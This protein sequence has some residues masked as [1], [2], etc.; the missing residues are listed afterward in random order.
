MSLS[1]KIRKAVVSLAVVSVT[2]TAMPV[3]LSDT[4]P[5]VSTTNTAEIEK[6]I[7]AETLDSTTTTVEP[8]PNTA[9]TTTAADP[10]AEVPAEATPNINFPGDGD[11]KANTAELITKDAPQEIQLKKND[12]GTHTLST[13][14]KATP[15]GGPLGI[16]NFKRLGSKLPNLVI[17]DVTVGTSDVIP[18]EYHPDLER[19]LGFGLLSVDAKDVS[20]TTDQKVVVTYTLTDGETEALKD[21]DGTWEF[22]NDLKITA[23]DKLTKVALQ[24]AN[25]LPDSPRTLRTRPWTPVVLSTDNIISPKPFPDECRS[26]RTQQWGQCITKRY[27]GPLNDEGLAFGDDA[28]H[29]APTDSFRFESRPNY[30]IYQRNWGANHYPQPGNRQLRFPFRHSGNRPG[31]IDLDSP[32]NTVAEQGLFFS[33]DHVQWAWEETP[34][35]NQTNVWRAHEFLIGG[36]YQDGTYYGGNYTFT[37]AGGPAGFFDVPKRKGQVPWRIYIEGVLNTEDPGWVAKASG[38]SGIQFTHPNNNAVIIITKRNFSP[39]AANIVILDKSRTQFDAQGFVRGAQSARVGLAVPGWKRMVISHI[40]DETRLTQPSDPR[41][42]KFA[43][44]NGFRVAGFVPIWAGSIPTLPELEINKTFNSFKKS[45]AD[46]VYVAEYD[47]T[48]TNSSKRQGE[49]TLKDMPKFA[50]GVTI[51]RFEVFRRVNFRDRWVTLNPTNGSYIVATKESIAPNTTKVFKVRALVRANKSRSEIGA[52]LCN[53]T[54]E[55]RALR[56]TV[57]LEVSGRDNKVSE[58]C[59]DLPEQNVSVSKVFRPGQSE[60]RR[61]HWV[62]QAVNNSDFYPA[63]IWIKDKLEWSPEAQIDRVT[64][65]GQQI[66]RGTDG[67]YLLKGSP[68]QPIRIAPSASTN[69]EFDV[70]WHFANEVRAATNPNLQCTGPNTGS[71]NVAKVFQRGANPVEIAACAPLALP[72]LPAITKSYDPIKS[73]PGKAV[74]TIRLENTTNRAIPITGWEDQDNF[75]PSVV[76]RTR[77]GLQQSGT[78]LSG[79]Q[80]RYRNR[81]TNAYPIIPPAGRRAVYGNDGRI[82]FELGVNEVIEREVTLNYSLPTNANDPT[83]RCQMVNG[84][85]TP[86]KGLYNKT[87]FNVGSRRVESIACGDVP[88]GDSTNLIITKAFDKVWNT[89][90]PGYMA[91]DY[92]IQVR[93]PELGA[94]RYDLIDTPSFTE[95]V[96]HLDGY[97]LS[98]P[99][100]S[101]TVKAP[102]LFNGYSLAQGVAIPPNTTHTYKI[103]VMVRVDKPYAELGAPQCSSTAVNRGLRNVAK[104]SITRGGTRTAEACAN[105]PDPNLTVTK[106]V[107]K[108]NSEPGRTRWNIEVSNQSNNYIA[109]TWVTDMLEGSPDI[110]VKRVAQ[111]GRDVRKD[112]VTGE[113]ALA[114]FSTAPIIVRP[115]SSIQVSVDVYWEFKDVKQ[116]AVSTTLQCRP[117]I[118]D[119]RGTGTYNTARMYQ[120][121][122]SNVIGYVEA[123]ACDSVERPALPPKLTKEYLPAKSTPGHAVYRLFIRNE[124]TTQMRIYNWIDEPG[125]T[126]A[127]TIKGDMHTSG[128]EITDIDVPKNPDGTYKV[129]P[130]GFGIPEADGGQ[131]FILNP[132][133]EATREIT[134]DYD[135]STAQGTDTFKCVTDAAGNLVPGNGLYNKTTLRVNGLIVE[136]DACGDIAD[137]KGGLAIIK[138]DSNSQ[139]LPLTTDYAFEIHDENGNVI[140]ALDQVAEFNGQRYPQT[141]TDLDLAKVFY[142]VE[143]K[144]PIGYQLLPKRVPF[145]L[146]RDQNGKVIA[147]VQDP[148][149]Y[150]AVAAL[151]VVNLPGGAAV[152]TVSDVRVGGELPKSGGS[153]VI[154]WLLAATSLMLAGAVTYRRARQ[155]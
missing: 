43:E 97:I 45:S 102:K 53:A 74:Y 59:S 69:V 19:E 99:F 117:N 112:P 57:T 106:T 27:T 89:N 133:Q 71:Y 151:T 70:H 147:E 34:A 136:K 56:N 111:N 55:N 145:K 103:R 86:G 64:V 66:T 52:P 144:A 140:S 128:G 131:S 81:N 47:L 116:A 96:T 49:Y 153:G 17:E 67:E 110:V 37:A 126:M 7:G 39:R 120:R 101:G 109:K 3:A 137:P 141:S 123:P 130:F 94:G 83:L 84:V 12:D 107:D 36:D 1:H 41:T 31:Q 44:V 35:R 28:N 95:G 42:K 14:F 30:P 25:D 139:Y 124:T 80:T 118:D 91:V 15:E 32:T 127:A 100:S 46:N 121:E 148:Q 38:S 129:P 135:V 10:A 92:T 6:L 24:N 88:A 105:M 119:A 98:S 90:Q 61:F 114:G 134:F 93:N 132:N 60:D 13:T 104:L 48:V 82:T 9:T 62:I 122:A 75:T 154:L 16:I 2:L 23:F 125:F 50:D 142:L 138:T 108:A 18:A 58:A 5:A 73:R 77:D 76:V 87:Y 22:A 72:S 65:G 20:R 54:S 155:S 33:R 150:P 8:S 113:Y 115:R 85:L 146:L 4:S 79:T 11:P 149:N 63:N 26:D 152:L 143:T 68:Q 29:A 21:E 51:D 78:G 40:S